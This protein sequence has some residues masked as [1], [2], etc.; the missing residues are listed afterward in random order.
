MARRGVGLSALGLGV[1]AS[2]RATPPSTVSV[3]K[4]IKC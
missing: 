2:D 3:E 4:G 1:T